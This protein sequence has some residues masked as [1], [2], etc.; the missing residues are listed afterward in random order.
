MTTN[1]TPERLRSLDVLRGFDMFWI[2]GGKPVVVGLVA[3]FSVEASDWLENRLQHPEWHGF[4]PYDLIFPLFLFIAGVSTVYSIANRLAKGDSRANL[5][6]HFIQRGLT[7]VLLG[8]LYNRLLSRDLASA[9]GWGEM[10]YASVLGRIGLA[11]MFAALIAANTQWRTQLIWVLGL[12]VGYWAALRF[13]PVPE[14]GAG[15]LAPGQ[16]LTDFIDQHV[17]PG[18]RQI[19]KCTADIGTDTVTHDVSPRSA[20]VAARSS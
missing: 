9:E 13:I 8:I 3:L 11:Y 6:R 20:S 1:R 12:L 15:D 16:T 14:Y 7:L 17:V 5:H 4:E 19:G 18:D 2:I 10:R